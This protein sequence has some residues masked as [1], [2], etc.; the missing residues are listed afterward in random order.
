MTPFSICD[1]ATSKLLY[2]AY[3]A[4]WRELEVTEH[5]WAT[6]AATKARLTRALL[7]AAAAGERDPVKLKRAA[8]NGG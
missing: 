8:L 7:D 1:E 6:H 2:E 5:P 3:E 4:A